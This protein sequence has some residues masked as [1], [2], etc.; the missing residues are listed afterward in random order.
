M[1]T[2]SVIMGSAVVPKAGGIPVSWDIP[3]RCPYWRLQL[4][5]H[6]AHP[7]RIRLVWGTLAELRLTATT[8]R[9]EPC[10]E[11]EVG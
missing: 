3:L 8:W 2:D 9:M 4:R 6:D 5:A 7:G 10:P 1:A 11:L